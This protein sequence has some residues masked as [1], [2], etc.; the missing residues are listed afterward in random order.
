MNYKEEDIEIELVI[1]EEDSEMI[2]RLKNIIENVSP[3]LP[4]QNEQC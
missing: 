4:Q 2:A 1:G 3:L